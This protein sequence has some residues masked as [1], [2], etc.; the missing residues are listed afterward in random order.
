MTPERWER[1]KTLY[2]TAMGRPARE[3]E[4]FLA[5]ACRAD[6]E[7]RAEVQRL[8]DQPLDTAGFVGLVGGSVSDHVQ[9]MHAV[10]KP[11]TGRRLGTF[12][13]KSL[14]GRGGMGPERIWTVA[15]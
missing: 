10:A 11:L 1:V 5:D 13:V 12:E 15:R 6:N 3:R 9:T 4:A 14:L 7:L 2:D 8:L